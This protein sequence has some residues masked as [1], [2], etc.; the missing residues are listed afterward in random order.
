MV[1]D[2]E[3]DLVHVLPQPEVD[4]LLFLEGFH[5]LEGTRKQGQ[6]PGGGPG[7]GQS[8]C[9]NKTSL[10]AWAPVSS[11][12]SGQGGRCRGAGHTPREAWII[13][14]LGGPRCV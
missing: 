10:G 14:P 4:L 8:Q 6:R 7:C 2:G 13:G 3:D 12:T 9:P 5:E 11:V 1:Q